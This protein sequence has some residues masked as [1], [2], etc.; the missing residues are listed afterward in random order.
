MSTRSVWER[1]PPLAVR[2]LLEEL[3]AARRR[4]FEDDA[5]ALPVLTV[6]T[7]SGHSISGHLLA[8]DAKTQDVVIEELAN[9][10]VTADLA[11]LAASE[12]A[13]VRVQQAL[14]AIDVVTRGEVELG[15][16][17]E[18]PALLVVRRETAA[19]FAAISERLERP[20]ALVVDWAPL[21]EDDGRRHSVRVV[22]EIIS[23]VI[24][25]LIDAFGADALGRVSSVRIEDGEA[26]GAAVEGEA[27]VLRVD[28]ARGRRGR[29]TERGL[30]EAI[31][32]A[33]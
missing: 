13:V 10:R 19:V 12:I 22:V 14:G 30:R 4:A 1:I 8:Y 25:S 15:P 20:I 2:T 33:L 17:V 21:A 3:L 18:V 7:K 26:I 9:A 6:M 16:R 28:L 24:G 27:L 31:E 5:I 32:R 29:M 11:Y 23:R